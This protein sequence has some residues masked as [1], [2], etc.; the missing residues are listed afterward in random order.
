V[1]TGGKDKY[2]GVNA[3]NQIVYWINGVWYRLHGEDRIGD[4]VWASIG[5]DGTILAVTIHDRVFMRDRGWWSQISGFNGHSCKQIYVSNSDSIAC[6]NA[7]G[8]AF[9][10]ESHSWHPVGS[11]QAFTKIAVSSNR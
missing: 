6:V 5:H 2:V 9:F 11:N 10:Y 1:S 3:Q 8:S 7:T 4:I